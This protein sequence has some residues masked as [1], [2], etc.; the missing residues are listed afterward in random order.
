MDRPVIRVIVVDDDDDM[1]SEVV[2]YLIGQG[3]DAIGVP[4]SAA[5]YRELLSRQA[6]IIVLDVTLPGE[7]GFSIARHLRS[8]ERTRSMGLIMLTGHADKED[9]V[10]GI[11][12]GADVYMVKPAEP[13]ELRAYIEGLYRRV[14]R[15]G[16]VPASAKWQYREREAVLL[17][18]SGSRIELSHLENQFL[19]VLARQPGQTIKRKDIIASA[20]GADPLTYDWRRL[21]AIVSRLRKKIHNHYPMVQPVRAVH[22]VGFIFSAAVELT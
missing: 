14:H 11:D 19:S 2:A 7:S 17:A 3:C 13:D 1:R 20:F 6:D 9:R 12:C 4:D 18:P 8:L 10:V 16:E 21:D 5:L 22:G 15:D